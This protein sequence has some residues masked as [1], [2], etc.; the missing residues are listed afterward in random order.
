MA[1]VRLEIHNREYLLEE[2]ALGI[3]E[4]R[5]FESKITGALQCYRYVPVGIAERLAYRPTE[6]L[7]IPIDRDIWIRQMVLATPRES[8][9]Q[10]MFKRLQ[11]WRCDRQLLQSRNIPI[12][13]TRQVIQE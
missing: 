10:N 3:D 5:L 9:W 2:R 7:P 13:T 12:R 11:D 1:A 8:A 4:A 6:T